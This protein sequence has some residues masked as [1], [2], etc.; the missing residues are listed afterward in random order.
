MS[1]D[2]ARLTRLLDDE[3]SRFRET[4][5]R[6]AELFTRTSKTL[7]GGVPMT[8]MRK[9]AGGFPIFAREARGAHVV[10]VDGHDYV[11]LCLGDT[12]AMAGHSAPAAV[13][14]IVD[15]ARRGLTL[16]LP[17]EDAVFVGEEMARRFGL[18]FWQFT[19]SASGANTEASGCRSC[20]MAPW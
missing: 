3:R 6:S 18:P 1:M 8:W 17:T 4:H 5:A 7:L 2:R 19:L 14:A 13:E 10:D 16:M 9:W 15:Q 12:G 11:D 20:C